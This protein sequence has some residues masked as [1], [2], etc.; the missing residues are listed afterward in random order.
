[1]ANIHVEDSAV[2]A[3]DRSEKLDQ[4]A[5]QSNE[6]LPI[7]DIIDAHEGLTFP[8]EEERITLRRVADSLPWNAYRRLLTPS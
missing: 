2:T 1:M 4:K 6:S 3:F 8:T 7:S 5:S